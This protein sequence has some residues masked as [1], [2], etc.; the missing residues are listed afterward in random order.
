MR[1]LDRVPAG[2]LARYCSPARQVFDEDKV[3]RSL[4]VRHR[5]AGDRF[6]PYGMSGSK[7]LKDYLVDARIPASKRDQLPLVVAE[8]TIIWVV[9]YAVSAHAAITADTRIVIEIEV[10]DA[11][12]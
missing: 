8:D 2:D 6:T 1:L 3:G 12:K 5:R 10:T 9:G 4:S 11:A 7:K